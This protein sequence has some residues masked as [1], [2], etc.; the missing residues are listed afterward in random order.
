MDSDDEDHRASD[1]HVRQYFHRNSNPPLKDNT[2]YLPFKVDDREVAPEVL[3]KYSDEAQAEKLKRGVENKRRKRRREE[4]KDHSADKT[5][6]KKAY[7]SGEWSLLGG[8]K[9]DKR[10]K[11]QQEEK[12]T[13]ILSYTPLAL[14]GTGFGILAYAALKK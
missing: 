2:Q 5:T 11:G 10:K 12:G 13:S 3:Q 8:K 1:P 4:K 9:Q 6:I 7:K 14:L